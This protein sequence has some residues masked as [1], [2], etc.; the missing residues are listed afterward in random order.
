[1]R[2]YV[3]C[4]YT[5]RNYARHVA[6]AL[7]DAGIE[8]SS[9]WFDR[10]GLTPEEIAE[11]DRDELEDSDTIIFLAV[12]ESTGGG[13][14]AEWGMALLM[15]DGYRKIVIGSF[16]EF[17]SPFLTLADEIYPD[18]ETFLDTLAVEA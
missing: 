12:G 14:W 9:H 4:P 8:I 15:G 11:A 5:Y 2:A 10:E 3:S 13:C 17:Q 16:N 7:A 1:M 18:V 6:H